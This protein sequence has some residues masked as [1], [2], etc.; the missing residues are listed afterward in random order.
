[1]AAALA[2][3]LEK[4]PADRFTSARAFSDALATLDF[5]HRTAGFAVTGA[6]RGPLME[7]R[8]KLLVTTLALAAVGGIGS[9]A[10]LVTRTDPLPVSMRFPLL[11]PDSV[12]L[13][14]GSGT[15]LAIS[16]DG[17]AILVVGRRNGIKGIYLR[18]IDDPVAELVRGTEDGNGTYNVSPRFS[19]DGQWIVYETED[20]VI[21]KI[22]VLGGT[23]QALADSVSGSFD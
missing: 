23:P 19:P 22:S 3:A 7:R 8:T 5:A 18:R 14:D 20:R 4:L 10:W 1:V 15:K 16:R 2:T 9:A 21:R 11:L 6:R 17:R 13:Y 12:R